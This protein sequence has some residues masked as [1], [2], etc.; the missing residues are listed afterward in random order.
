MERAWPMFVLGASCILVT[1]I[2]FGILCGNMLRARRMIP[3]WHLQ[4]GT[5]FLLGKIERFQREIEEEQQQYP[6]YLIHSQSQRSLQ[7]SSSPLNNKTNKYNTRLSLVRSISSFLAIRIKVLLQ[8][9]RQQ[10]SPRQEF[11][12]RRLKFIR[13]YTFLINISLNFKIKLS[14]FFL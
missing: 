12:I 13:I 9:Y 1:A 4:S 5:D 2:V 7:F 6:I 14:S 11:M 8:T 10:T 3:S